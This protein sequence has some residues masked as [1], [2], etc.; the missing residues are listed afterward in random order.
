MN[1]IK[2]ISGILLIFF[3]LF[4]SFSIVSAADNA[5]DD[6]AATSDMSV[7]VEED[8]EISDNLI[9]TNI[10]V[11]SVDSYYKEKT[12]LTGYLK[13]DDGNF[14]ENKTVSVLVNGVT[15]N[16][17]TDSK[18]K[19]FLPIHLASGKYNVLINFLG[20]KE[21]NST[22]A[23]T[24]IKINKAPV[25]V[26]S[27]DFSTYVGSD[28]FFTAKVYNSVTKTPMSG[29]K[30]LFKVY[31]TKAKK[32]VYYYKVT[33]GKGIATLNKN[34]K[35][36]SY[37]VY[38][39]VSNKH[40]SS[41]S[42]KSTIKIKPT[43]EVGCCS[44]YLQV[45]GSEALT[46]FR[47]DSTYAAYILVKPTTWY[48]RPV[49][50]Q[51]KETNSYSFHLIVTADGWMVGTGG[52]DNPTIN[53]NIERLAAQMISD[54]CIQKAKLHQIKRYISY[55][56]IGHFAIKAPN[57]RYAAI[58]LNGEKYGVLK[59]GQ[60]IS[61]PNYKSCF[62]QG[63]YASFSKDPATAAL[64]IA[65]TDSYG[66]NKRVILVHHWKATT[67][68]FKTTAT[69]KSYA[70]NDDGRFSGRSTAHLKDNIGYKGTFISR[71]SL[72]YPTKKKWLGT[73]SF[74]NIDKIV[75]QN[76]V[77]TAPKVSNKLGVTSYFKATVK[78]KAGKPLS[79][80]NI[81]IKVYNSKFSKTYVLR[82]DS[83]GVVKLDTKLLGIG[84][85]N[86][87]ITQYNN[88]YWSSTQTSIVIVK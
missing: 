14:I 73:H 7:A 67:K 33:D 27:K 72:P 32:Y 3:V 75:K 22:F 42:S 53:R 55:L 17:T 62:R 71:N 2:T 65:A 74:G 69:L 76:V 40:V 1:K 30:V 47:R 80:V 37:V 9:N 36:G 81:Q 79:P 11:N 51:Y 4:L 84:T 59:P 64:K 61:V 35:E 45:S 60:Y 26:E 52:A 24:I 21:Y 56:G 12:D 43:A 13:D 8:A 44:F 85:Y 23:S 63:S 31:D 83:N 25:T 54:G 48:G 18:G 77:V 29:V 16:R 82:T 19:F 46:G 49:I 38:T 6:G 41:K 39:S 58:W 66:V 86:V 57:G 70:A 88:R 5:T 87:L 34:L 20:D 78:N 15:Y 28:I 10:E 68:D 50:K